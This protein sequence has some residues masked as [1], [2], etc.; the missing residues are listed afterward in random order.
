MKFALLINS[1][2][3]TFQASDTAYQFCLAALQQGH[4]IQQVFFYHDA[5]YIGSALACPPQD[6]PNITIRWQTLATQHNIELIICVAA[7]LK[8][9]ILSEE[10]ASLYAKP[11]FN[12][13]SGFKIAGLGQLIQASLTAD[14]I[15]EFG[16]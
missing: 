8:R 3:Y 13:A 7:A 15:V 11:G 6:E 2:P 1:S 10:E 14:R 9:G 5:V 16:H 4:V 12:L